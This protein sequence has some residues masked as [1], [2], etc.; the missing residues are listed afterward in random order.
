M[1]KQS[2]IN[3]WNAFLNTLDGGAVNDNS[4]TT[5]PFGG[6]ASQ[7]RELAELVKSGDKTATSSLYVLYEMDKEPI[8]KVGEYSVITD[9]NGEARAIIKNTDVTIM[10]F[11]EVDASFACKEGEGDKSLGYW[12]RVHIDFFTHELKELGMSFSEDMY[13]VCEEFEV[14][15]Q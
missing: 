8:P 5:W 7:A 3:I 1:I 12:R 14:V 4:Y 15:Y 13:V 10:P 2:V 6:N 11:H 9:W